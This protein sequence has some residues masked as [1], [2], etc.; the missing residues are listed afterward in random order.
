M[1]RI[2]TILTSLLTLISIPQSA[3]D[4]Q[5]P[6]SS[7]ITRWESEYLAPESEYGPGHRGVDLVQDLGSPIKAPVSGKIYFAGLVVDRKVV[8]IRSFSGYLASFE[9]AC[10]ELK[11]GDVV[12]IGDQFAWHCSPQ[13]SYEYHCESCVHFSVRSQ[14]GYL[15]PDFFL[16]KMLPSVILG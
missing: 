9:P 13:A 8:T 5:Q 14:F 11:V 6:F 2:A 1:L 12:L 3:G 10:T 15:S 7:E 4:W 16:S